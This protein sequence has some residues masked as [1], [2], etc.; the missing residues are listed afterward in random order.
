MSKNFGKVWAF[1]WD[2]G[3]PFILP[4]KNPNHQ[5]KLRSKNQIVHSQFMVALQSILV[6]LSQIY[7]Q[8]WLILHLKLHIGFRCSSTLQ[9]A[10]PQAVYCHL[11]W[12]MVTSVFIKLVLLVMIL[13]IVFLM[14]TYCRQWCRLNFGILMAIRVTQ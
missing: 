10:C 4:D 6:L 14:G 9:V 2:N 7:I 12:L 5:L 13:L 1:S 3:C 11:L 8:I